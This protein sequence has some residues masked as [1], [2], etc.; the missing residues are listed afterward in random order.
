V[1]VPKHATTDPSIGELVKDV[2]T[3]LS[4]VIHGE[5]ELAKLELKKSVRFGGIG[6]ALF[7]LAGIVAVFALTF[8]F[9]ALAEGLI[10][11]GLWR[12]AAYL[13]VFGF[14]LL[15]AALSAFIGYKQVRR[16]RAPAR[17]I[18]TTKDTVSALKAAASHA[19][20]T[21]LPSSTNR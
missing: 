19:P 21:S 8:G 4:T 20:T 10:A 18:S 15:V 2:S 17:T 5:I 12:W 16:V 14:L 11:A 9:I 6:V 13:A 7:V 3:H 1:T